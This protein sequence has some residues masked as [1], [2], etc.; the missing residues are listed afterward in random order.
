MEDMPCIDIWD[1]ANQ[2]VY[3]RSVRRVTF[4]CHDHARTGPVV[5]GLVYQ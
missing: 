3:S 4:S 1:A 2:K 5:L